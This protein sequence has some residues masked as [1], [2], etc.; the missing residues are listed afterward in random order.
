MALK[1]I[2][3]IY[4]SATDVYSKIGLYSVKSLSIFIISIYYL[5][6]SSIMSIIIDNIIPHKTYEELKQ[7]ST[8]QIAVEISIIV[9]TIA[10]GYYLVRN[11]LS[12]GPLFFD[13]WFFEGLYGYKH[14]RLKEASTG[15]IVVGN[16][17]FFFQDRLRKR[18]GEFSRRFTF[19]MEA[20]S[21]P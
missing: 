16:V 1:K 21:P 7:M 9:G 11:L 3:T 4:K 8:I 19:T 5:F 6:F 15:G 18:L 2:K 17:I 20:T 14:E 12:G 13:K 10:V